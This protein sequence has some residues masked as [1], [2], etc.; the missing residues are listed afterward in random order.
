MFN[1]ENLNKVDYKVHLKHGQYIH[2]SP[3]PWIQ[4]SIVTYVDNNNQIIQVNDIKIDSNRR[5]R[6]IAELLKEKEFTDNVGFLFSELRTMIADEED[7]E[8]ERF[9]D[10]IPKVFEMDGTFFIGGNEIVVKNKK[11]IKICDFDITTERSKVLDKLLQSSDLR[12]NITRLKIQLHEELSANEISPYDQEMQEIG[13]EQ[14]NK[15]LDKNPAAKINQNI[16]RSAE[17]IEGIEQEKQIKNKSADA[18]ISKTMISSLKNLY[19]TKMVF[20]DK[21]IQTVEKGTQTDPV[22]E[23]AFTE[24]NAQEQP[25]S[26]YNNILTSLAGFCCCGPRESVIHGKIMLGSSISQPPPVLLSEANHYYMLEYNKVITLMPLQSAGNNDYIL[27]PYNMGQS[28]GDTDCFARTLVLQ[29]AFPTGNILMTETD[30][31][32]VFHAQFVI[33]PRELFTQTLI[34]SFESQ[35]YES[36]E[37]SVIKS[38]SIEPP[39]KEIILKNNRNILTQQLLTIKYVDHYLEFKNGITEKLHYYSYSILSSDVGLQ[40]DLLFTIQKQ[41]YNVDYPAVTDGDLF[42]QVDLGNII[43]KTA[44]GIAS[45]FNFAKNLGKTC[46]SIKDWLNDTTDKYT[47]MEFG[48]KASKIGTVI[49][50]TTMNSAI[51]DYFFTQNGMVVE[52]VYTISSK[53]YSEDNKTG[54]IGITEWLTVKVKAAD[55]VLGNYI[56]KYLGTSRYQEM[57]DL[58]NKYGIN[59]TAGEKINVSND[60]EL[61]RAYRKIALVT[62]PDKHNGD[63]SKETDFLKAQKLLS[64]DSSTD[65]KEVLYG[66]LASNVDRAYQVTNS[67]NV[68]TDGMRLIREPSQ[69]HFLEFGVDIGY[70]LEKTMGYNIGMKYIAPTKMIY[71]LYEGQYSEVMKSGLFMAGYTLPEVVMTTCPVIGITLKSA[72]VV[73]AF[74]DVGNDLYNEINYLLGNNELNMP[75]IAAEYSDN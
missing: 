51:G 59:T 1:Q 34:Y 16:E 52:D 5:K 7:G 72:I 38:L 66:N 60:N 70:M 75:S 33:N 18:A 55:D 30:T 50:S 4:K 62:H 13:T 36:V 31:P 28:T 27:D 40:K 42:P 67:L 12:G 6:I 71:Q 19:Q 41:K 23:E 65:S 45:T 73:K 63:I 46:A 49:Y 61:N 56:F 17:Q 39:N 10:E 37:L 3:D 54:S 29:N 32:L 74:Y 2:H 21:V 35:R 44:S 53:D 57:Q 15:E 25:E 9:I 24:G 47:T 48:I 69:Y 58:A 43:D 22:N 8:R 11:I 20:G 26:W 14:I 64:I 68:V